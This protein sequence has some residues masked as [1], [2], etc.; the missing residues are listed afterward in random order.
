MG[1]VQIRRRVADSEKEPPAFRLVG[2]GHPHGASTSR[3]RIRE[4]A[5]HGLRPCLAAELSWRGDGEKTPELLTGERIER[6]QGSARLELTSRAS[7]NDDVLAA[8]GAP[9][10]DLVPRDEERRH[11]Q[12]DPK[13]V[14]AD[15]DR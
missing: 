6:G 8:S 12:A 11:G 4:R 9:G 5:L 10:R 13:C 15:G 2:W 14:V 3:V 7:D 1:A